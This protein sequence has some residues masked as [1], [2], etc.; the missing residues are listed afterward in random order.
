[1][2]SVIIYNV[3]PQSVTLFVLKKVFQFS[4]SVTVSESVPV[5]ENVLF[6]ELFGSP[7]FWNHFSFR[8][9]LTAFV[10]FFSIFHLF[11]IIF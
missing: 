9:I 7:K 3:S 4:K 2:L 1:M 8:I 10:L 5:W 11:Y 6:L